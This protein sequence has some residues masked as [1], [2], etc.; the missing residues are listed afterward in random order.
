M[1]AA[2]FLASPLLLNRS[3][4]VN[5]YAGKPAVRPAAYS[6]DIESIPRWLCS[7]KLLTDLPNRNTLAGPGNAPL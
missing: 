3:D 2:G 1:L 5:L 6:V 7:L 4:V